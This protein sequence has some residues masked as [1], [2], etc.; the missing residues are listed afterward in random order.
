MNSV[1][2]R[3][4][5]GVLF[6]ENERGLKAGVLLTV[7]SPQCGMIPQQWYY[8]DICEQYQEGM[9]T[10]EEWDGQCSVDQQV[11]IAEIP[12][13]C[14]LN[15]IFEKKHTNA[16]YH[17]CQVHVRE[18]NQSRDIFGIRLMK[19]DIQVLETFVN[20]LSFVF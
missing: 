18:T 5:D 19:E 4:Q 17:I 15:A 1:F 14:V 20:V 10:Q 11:F 6:V 2:F 8:E 3:G 16:C 12:S 9:V 7:H 13:L